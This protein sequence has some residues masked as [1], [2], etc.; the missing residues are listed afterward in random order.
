[1]RD[2]RIRVI[3]QLHSAVDGSVGN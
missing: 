1:M 2:R 3:G